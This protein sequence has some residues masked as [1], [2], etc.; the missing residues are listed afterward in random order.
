[1]PQEEQSEPAKQ[2]AQQ[3]EVLE[4]AKKAEDTE[5]ATPKETVASAAPQKPAEV[6][7]PEDATQEK[8]AAVEAEEI[9]SNTLTYINERLTKLE[10]DVACLNE[11]VDSAPPAG[12]TGS[13]ELDDL[14]SKIH[15]IQADM[16]KLNQTADH[17]IDDRENREV[18]LNV[19]SKLL[20]KDT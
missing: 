15:G 5:T 10:K 3:A 8:G 6:P 18:H 13:A 19:S 11:K 9:D 20:T 12:T 17:L 1:M 14:V 7:T 4:D 2:E 16:E